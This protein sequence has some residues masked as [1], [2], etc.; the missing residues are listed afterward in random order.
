MSGAPRIVGVRHHSPACA[1]LVRETIRAERPARVLIEGPADFNERLDELYLDHRLPIAIFSYYQRAERTYSSWS[2]LCDYSPEWVA[3]REGRDA[4]AEVRFIDLP[5]WTHAFVGVRNRYSDRG[6]R[7]LSYVERLC[8][9]LGVDGLDALWDHLFEQP[10]HTDALAARLDAYF[11]ALRG[12][13]DGRPAIDGDDAREAMMAAHVAHAMAE[14]A[15]PVVVVCGG[16]HAP[17][18]ARRWREVD[19]PGPPRVPTPGAD[20]RHGSY[21][22][23]YSFRRLDSFTGYEAGMPSPNY[24]QQL[25]EHGPRVAGE[26][27]LEAAVRRLRDKRQP[28]SAADLIAAETMTRGLMRL[29]GHAA[30]SRTDLLDGV[31][32]ALLKEAQEAPLP[33]TRRGPIPAGTDPRLVVVLA[34]LS[35][36]RRGELAPDTPRPPLIVDVHEVLARHDLTPGDGAPRTRRLDL[37]DPAQ[38]E[39]SQV[40]H[41]LRVLD[42]PGFVRVK[43]PR[44]AVDPQ[45]DEVWELTRS[46]DADAALVEAAAFGATLEAAAAARLGEHLRAAGADLEALAQVLAEALFVGLGALAERVIAEARAQ[47]H[48]EPHLGRL[49]A[50]LSLLL[51]LWRHDDLLGAKGAPALGAVVEAMV[52]RGLWL[53]EGRTGAHAATPREELRAVVALRD[54]VRHGA[55]ALDVDPAAARA[56]MERRAADRAAP[57]GYRGAA[58]GYLW[59]MRAF[60][61]EA[62]AQARAERAIRGAGGPEALGELLAGLFA[63]AREEVVAAGGLVEAL[64]AIL[65][66][67]SE[68]EFLIA[69]PSLRLAF[70]WF[71]PRERDALARAVL[72]LRGGGRVASLRTLEVDAAVAVRAA[73]LEARVDDLEARYGLG[74]DDG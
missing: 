69:V 5:A 34:A 46:L 50:G 32:A 25:W 38:R 39:A 26:R 28:L 54:A 15:G 68:R 43:G 23:P 7:R 13:D 30:M 47:V 12:E 65:A 52:R 18:L 72:G 6:R 70:A 10:M 73:A 9:K 55:G 62:T 27:M 2:P 8:R 36:A 3:L 41:R 61:E 21:L 60:A 35:G 57:P 17:A 31:A 51:A 44:T 40:L 66:E 29:R 56:V 14:D 20:V 1:R 33:W 74:G 67:L 64:D 19:A 24:Y 42:V 45:L 63:L 4:G 48:D 71:P 16:Y 49:G 22:V 59:S 11:E 53:F 58:L 37:T